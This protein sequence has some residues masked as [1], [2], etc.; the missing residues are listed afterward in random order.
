MII[1]FI[2][3]LLLGIGAVVFALQNTTVIT[4]TFI[5]WQITGSLSLIILLAILC[6]VLASLLLFLPESMRSYARYRR[7]KK[8]NIELENKLKKQKE[9]ETFAAKSAPPTQEDL[10]RIENG[11]VEDRVL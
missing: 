8:A 7:L 5:H 3:G 4:V 10:E 1:L 2:L 11:V 6:G 9:S